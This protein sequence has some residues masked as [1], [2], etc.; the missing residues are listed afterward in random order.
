MGRSVAMLAICSGSYVAQLLQN[1]AKRRCR[2]DVRFH[3]LV[4]IHGCNVTD[5]ETG[6]STPPQY[7]VIL[8]GGRR[9]S[10][11]ELRGECTDNGLAVREMGVYESDE[12]HNIRQEQNRA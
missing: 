8:W 6:V 5:A 7:S 2:C 1:T 4:G 9:D 3:V 11:F 12:W 10:S